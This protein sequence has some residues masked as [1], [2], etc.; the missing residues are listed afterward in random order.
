MC[1]LVT[2]LQVKTGRDNASLESEDA[3]WDGRMA[4][5]TMLFGKTHL[6]SMPEIDHV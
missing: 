1:F 5:R 3:L 4:S 6:L 2:I